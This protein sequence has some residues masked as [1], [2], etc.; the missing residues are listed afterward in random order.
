M[1]KTEI[2]VLYILTT[3]TQKAIVIKIVWHWHKGKQ[4]G[5]WN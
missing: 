1:V 3:H 5:Q 2:Y 4:R